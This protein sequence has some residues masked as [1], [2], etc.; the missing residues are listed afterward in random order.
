MESQDAVRELMNLSLSTI[1]S[2]VSSPSPW[3]PENEQTEESMGGK[4]ST[5][6]RKEIPILSPGRIERAED[7]NLE[8]F[9]SPISDD[10]DVFHC[11]LELL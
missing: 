2:P 7:Y 3:I 8:H 9:S 10:F 4:Q 11:K 1:N 5:A 6:A